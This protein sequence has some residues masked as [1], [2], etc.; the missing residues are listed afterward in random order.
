MPWRTRKISPA[1]DFAM[2]D[3]VSTVTGWLR[4]KPGQYYCQRCI[5]EN[6][7][8]K[9]EAQVNQIIRPLEQAREWR[10][11]KTMCDGCKRERK[12]VAFAG[13]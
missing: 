13:M 11:R 8:V 2:S 12:C 4:T 10:Y 7:G 6:T 3:N 5:T 1:V 9:P